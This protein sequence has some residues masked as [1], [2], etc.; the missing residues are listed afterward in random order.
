MRTS[1]IIFDRRMSGCHFLGSPRCRSCCSARF[2]RLFSLHE[3][4][5]PVTLS[6]DCANWTRRFARAMRR[7][8]FSVCSSSALC[9]L[10][11]KKG[12]MPRIT[13]STRRMHLEHLTSP[14][15]SGVPNGLRED[16]GMW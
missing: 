10:L 12:W 4:T 15:S 9:L 3:A 8:S 7:C 14:R 16:S 6:R 1:V 2:F 11:N 13:G 5:S